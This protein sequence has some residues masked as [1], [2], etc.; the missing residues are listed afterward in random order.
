MHPH[1]RRAP[2]VPSRAHPSRDDPGGG[3]ASPIA[4]VAH[5]RSVVDD[6]TDARASE[7]RAFMM[8]KSRRASRRAMDTSDAP[9]RAETANI[10]VEESDVKSLAR[11]ARGC[12]K[13]RSWK[14]L[15]G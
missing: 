1:R 14:T 8:D 9:V 5:H 4:K 7:T 6:A 2:S 3:L 10:V 15:I 13:V 11:G 12:E